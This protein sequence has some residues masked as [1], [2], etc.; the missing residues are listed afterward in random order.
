MQR[1][2]RSVRLTKPDF[3]FS[4]HVHIETVLVFISIQLISKIKTQP[5]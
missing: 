5:I 2:I 4:E 1:K 3:P